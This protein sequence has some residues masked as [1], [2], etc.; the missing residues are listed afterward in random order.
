MLDSINHVIDVGTKAVESGSFLLYLLVSE[1]KRALSCVVSVCFLE[2][3]HKTVESIVPRRIKG[4]EERERERKSINREKRIL[5]L[6][7]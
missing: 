6:G 1:R 3:S 5:I 2:S 7:D 4:R